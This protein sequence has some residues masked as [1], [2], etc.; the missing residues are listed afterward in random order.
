M[1]KKSFKDEDKKS[2]SLDLSTDYLDNSN[3]GNNRKDNSK[4][5]LKENKPERKRHTFLLKV[6]HLEKLKDYVYTKR[7]EGDTEFTQQDAIE[8]MFDN[9][10]NS[11]KIKSRPQKA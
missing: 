9:F 7:I 6:T 5:K 1:A 8:E 11:V 4:D 3:L 10:F 2:K